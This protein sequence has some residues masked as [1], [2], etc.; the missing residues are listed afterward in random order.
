MN[1][2]FLP[3]D[4]MTDEQRAEI[5]SLARLLG[6]E[7]EINA[8]AA[9]LSR[10]ELESAYTHLTHWEAEQIIRLMTKDLRNKPLPWHTLSRFPQ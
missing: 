9:Y 8:L 5:T 1:L 2:K 4:P 7:R 10:I 3:P 6:Y